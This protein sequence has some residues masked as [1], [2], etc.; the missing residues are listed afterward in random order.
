MHIMQVV[1]IRLADRAR[2]ELSNTAYTRAEA[3]L[4]HWTP[5]GNYRAVIGESQEAALEMVRR[6][7][8]QNLVPAWLRA[9]GKVFPHHFE[10]EVSSQNVE[11]FRF[12]MSSQ[13]VW[14]KWHQIPEEP[15]ELRA[16]KEAS[17]GQEPVAWLFQHEETGRTQC[18]EAYQVECGF[19]RNNPRWQKIGPLYLHPDPEAAKEFAEFV[20]S[21]S[22]GLLENLAKLDECQEAM[23]SRLKELEVQAVKLTSQRDL[24]IAIRAGCVTSDQI[25]NLHPKPQTP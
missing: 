16:F 22:A 25:S 5:R 3:W 10:F 18:V 23:Q 13:V 20:E 12:W 17:E 21:N 14:C 15:Y 8:H 11:D 7:L 1:S 19:E 4:T 24:W 2:D 9:E 6:D